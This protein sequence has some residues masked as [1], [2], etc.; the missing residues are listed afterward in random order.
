MGREGEGEGE[1]EG[2]RRE[3]ERERERK[4]GEKREK[5]A[6][7][8][9]AFASLRAAEHALLSVSLANTRYYADQPLASFSACV[10]A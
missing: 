7:H 1:S 6:C 8:T 5:R 4:R 3:G 2:K 9:C 10:C